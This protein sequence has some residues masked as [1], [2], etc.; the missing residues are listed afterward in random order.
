MSISAHT[1][2][3]LNGLVASAEQH[4]KPGHQRVHVVVA[5]E[6][7]LERRGERQVCH[8]HLQNVD[9]LQQT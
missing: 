7:H 4:V 8:S 2:R 5:S 6:A 9:R 1:S 3:K